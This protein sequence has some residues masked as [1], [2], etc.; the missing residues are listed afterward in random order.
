MVLDF[1]HASFDPDYD[2]VVLVQ[3][4]ARVMLDGCHSIAEMQD[5]VPFDINHALLV[6]EL[7]HMANDN[8]RAVEREW[9]LEH[10]SAVLYSDLLG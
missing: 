1:V 4:F 2:H 3:D 9:D 5:H 10:E 7:Y 8:N 6:R